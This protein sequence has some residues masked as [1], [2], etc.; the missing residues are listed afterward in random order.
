MSKKIVSAAVLTAVVLGL[1]A[2][3]VEAKSAPKT[4]AECEKVSNMKWDDATSKCVKK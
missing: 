4:K 3:A 2:S 1:G